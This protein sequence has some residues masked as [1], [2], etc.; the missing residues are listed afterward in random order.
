MR[1]LL[2][3]TF[4]VCLLLAGAALIYKQ[5]SGTTPFA[6]H[7]FALGGLLATAGL[8]WMFLDIVGPE[9]RRR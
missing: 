2:S 1:K 3:A 7:V 9:D 5:I 8:A 4:A 6:I